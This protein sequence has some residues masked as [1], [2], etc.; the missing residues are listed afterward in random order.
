[1]FDSKGTFKR[2]IRHENLKTPRYLT[3]DSEDNILVCDSGA[4]EVLVFSGR[5][6]GLVGR[7]KGL[8]GPIGVTIDGEGRILVTKW[9]GHKISIF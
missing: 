1:M 5:T 4:K 9:A 2:V 6:G 7:L 8:G 3:V